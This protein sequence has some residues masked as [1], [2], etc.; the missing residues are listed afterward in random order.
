MT[1]W[2]IQKSNKCFCDWLNVCKCVRDFRLICTP[3]V[4]L[5][6]PLAP[7]PHIT[8]PCVQLSNQS[9]GHGKQLKDDSEIQSTEREKAGSLTQTIDTRHNHSINM[10]DGVDLSRL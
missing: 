3:H 6:L 5:R 7:C 1:T 10:P 8:P 4:G 2:E 9:D